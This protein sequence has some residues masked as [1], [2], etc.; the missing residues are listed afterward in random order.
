V[1]PGGGEAGERAVDPGRG[2]GQ[3]VRGGCGWC[4]QGEAAAAGGEGPAAM[5]WQG[6]GAAWAEEMRKVWAGEGPWFAAAT[7]AE[8]GSEDER[9]GPGPEGGG[10][11]CRVGSGETEQGRQD[12]GGGG[13]CASASPVEGPEAERAVGA[14]ESQRRRLL[15]GAAA[16]TAGA[17]QGRLQLA[18]PVESR[19][20]TRGRDRAKAAPRT[21][22]AGAAPGHR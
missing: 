9:A 15:R 1:G 3:A 5:A 7:A 6:E 16:K 22:S 20:V 4:G 14:K 13:T 8:T 11:R 12:G 21:G 18:T 19:E 17:L 2:P 10:G